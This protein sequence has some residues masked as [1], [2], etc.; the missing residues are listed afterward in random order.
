M[1]FEVEDVHDAFPYWLVFKCLAN[2]HGLSERGRSAVLRLNCLAQLYSVR[3]RTKRHGI[4]QLLARRPTNVATV[5]Y[6]NKLARIAWA[7]M[8]HGN[9]YNP[10]LAFATI[11]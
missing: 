6:A 11:P 4:E 7:I 5:A 9:R 1:A 10:A 8:M 3:L 2:G